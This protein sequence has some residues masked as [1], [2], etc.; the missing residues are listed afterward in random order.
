MLGVDFDCLFHLLDHIIKSIQ[1]VIGCTEMEM[2]IRYLRVLFDSF[3]ENLSRIFITVGL[4][5]NQAV[6]EI[7]L[8][9]LVV[10]FSSQ[11]SLLQRFIYFFLFIEIESAQ[12]DM[13]VIKFTVLFQ[14]ILIERDRL[15]GFFALFIER[16]KID[17]EPE[18][19]RS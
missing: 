19:I 13:D 5:Q 12:P 18:I 14:N 17:A 1:L 2:K 9:P 3:D 8:R 10:D 15:L 6:K 4:I 7:R 11:L 16:R